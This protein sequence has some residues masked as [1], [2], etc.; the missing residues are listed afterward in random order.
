MLKLYSRHIEL[1]YIYQFN[2]KYCTIQ[3]SFGFFCMVYGKPEQTLLANPI[4]Y[5][6]LIYIFNS[7][8]N[9]PVSLYFNVNIRKIVITL[10][11]APL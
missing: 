11:M 9:S 7:I 4:Y 8:I 10:H 1:K 2:I 5:I 3:S 6:Y